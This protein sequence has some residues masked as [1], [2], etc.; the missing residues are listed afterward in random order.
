L[1]RK[2]RI[3]LGISMVKSG[4]KLLIV[5]YYSEVSAPFEFFFPVL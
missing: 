4:D 5:N 1:R 3:E 2:I